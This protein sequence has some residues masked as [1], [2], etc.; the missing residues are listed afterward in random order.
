MLVLTQYALKSFGSRS[1]PGPGVGAHSALPDPLTG[2][3]GPLTGIR[4]ASRKGRKGRRSLEGEGRE[5]KEAEGEE[6]KKE[7][8]G[9]EG[10]KGKLAASLLENKTPLQQVIS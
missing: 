8:K 9:N 3:R 7:W 10:E 5:V 6:G 2:I 1:L 4:D